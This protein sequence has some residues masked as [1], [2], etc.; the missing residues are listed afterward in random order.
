MRGKLLFVILAFGLVMA[1]AP[2]ARAD[3][4]FHYKNSGG[5]TLVAKGASLPSANTCESL[6]LYEREGQPPSPFTRG[7]EGAATGSICQDWA[8][9]TVILHYSYEACMGPESYFES[10]TCRL[11]LDNGNLPTTGSSCRGT[12]VGATSV[13]QFHNDNDAVLEP[14]EGNDVNWRVPNDPA[15]LCLGRSGFFHKGSDQ[16]RFS[17]EDFDQR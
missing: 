1:S 17:P 12:Y 6:A 7:L 4:C 5:G 3:M 9:A 10:G 11:Q 14:C 15:S 16:S 2:S 13:G 8:G